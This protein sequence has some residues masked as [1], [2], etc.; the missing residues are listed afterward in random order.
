LPRFAG[1]LGWS[2]DR[3]AAWL[4]QLWIAKLVTAWSRD[5]WLDRDDWMITNLPTARLDRLGACGA[6]PEETQDKP[7]GPDH[8]SD[9]QGDRGRAGGP[10]WSASWVC[11]SSSFLVSH[12]QQKDG[13]QTSVVRRRERI[14]G[15]HAAGSRPSSTIYGWS[16]S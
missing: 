3:F 14:A 15:I 16:T 4:G 12:G 10:P 5:S 7:D 11:R 8:V 6:Q 1:L 2:D 13:K 9:D